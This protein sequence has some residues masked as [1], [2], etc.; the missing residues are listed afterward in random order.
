MQQHDINMV[1]LEAL[2][3]ALHRLLDCRGRPGLTFNVRESLTAFRDQDIIV[4]SMTDCFADR[5][6]RAAVISGCIDQIDTS[7]E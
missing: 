6:F 7:I 3:R 1:G 2:E 5:L 4:A